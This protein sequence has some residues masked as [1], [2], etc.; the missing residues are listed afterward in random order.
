VVPVNDRLAVAI[1]DA[2]SY[3]LKSTF[4]AR[5]LASVFH[6]LVLDGATRR[7]G[8]LLSAVDGTILGNEYLGQLSM[9]CLYV[10]TAQQT[11]HLANAGHPYPVHYSARRRKADV[12]PM[13]GLLLSTST[14]GKATQYD[15][16]AIDF[17]PGDILVLVSDGL[18][19]ANIA[20]EDPYGYRFAEIMESKAGADAASI[21]RAI[22]EDWRAYPRDRN[23]GD[24]VS[25]LVI[26]FRGSG[27]GVQ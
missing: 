11:I 8:A 18:T 1:G 21:G 5:F 16:F 23:V 12:L 20:D 27:D 10:E 4:V 17:E 14:S 15:E 25:L 24:D 9:Q 22:L 13:P 2:P 6:D 26:A 7:V 19:E 3:G